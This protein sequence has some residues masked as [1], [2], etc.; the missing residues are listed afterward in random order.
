[1][2]HPVWMCGQ[3]HQAAECLL[4]VERAVSGESLPDLREW[5]VGVVAQADLVVE[6]AQLLGLG[7]AP[8]LRRGGGGQLVAPLE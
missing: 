2:C 6:V 1:M 7:R 5:V 8:R 3:T 4:V